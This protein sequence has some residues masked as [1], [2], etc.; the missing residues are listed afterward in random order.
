MGQSASS[1]IRG[2]IG[3]R[4]YG[5]TGP[6]RP[7]SGVTCGGPDLPSVPKVP[8]S[9]YVSPDWTD[10]LDDPLVRDTIKAAIEI[11]RQMRKGEPD[12]RA[13]AKA[14]WNVLGAVANEDPNHA[15][16]LCP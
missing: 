2:S 9:V 13:V 1:G 15:H 16:F 11:V 6:G 10:A 8:P 4:P 5:W 7:S 14:T 3:R 12:E